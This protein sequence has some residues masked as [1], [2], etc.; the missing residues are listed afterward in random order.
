MAVKY[1]LHPHVACE[2]VGGRHFLIA[3]GAAAGTLPYLREINETGSFF[4][5]LA[6][7]GCDSGAMLER[8]LETYEAPEKILEDGIKDFFEDLAGRGYV[9]IWEETQSPE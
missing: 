5:K 9:T 7:E 3:C 2:E 1:I 4:W 6:E 8:A